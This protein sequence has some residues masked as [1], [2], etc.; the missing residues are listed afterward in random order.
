MSGVKILFR[1]SP[2]KISIVRLKNPT[3]SGKK[4]ELFITKSN[5]GCISPT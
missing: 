3:Y 5:I 1:V 4:F 2:I